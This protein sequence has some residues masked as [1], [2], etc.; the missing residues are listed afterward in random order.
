MLK[1]KKK[2]MKKEIHSNAR[3]IYIWE[4]NAGEWGRTIMIEEIHSL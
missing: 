3:A 4:I 2:R 1:I